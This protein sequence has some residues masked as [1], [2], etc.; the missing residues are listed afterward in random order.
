MIRVQCGM[1]LKNVTAHVFGDRASGLT[2]HPGEVL[3]VNHNFIDEDCKGL[4][5][6]FEGLSQAV[7]C[8][9]LQIVT[10]A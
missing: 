4:G 1:R 10:G 3:E 6:V 5:D 2:F 8:G 9:H 7:N